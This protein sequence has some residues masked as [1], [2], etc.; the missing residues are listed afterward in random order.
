MWDYHS[1][2]VLASKGS[3]VVAIDIDNDK[4]IKIRNGVS[5]FFEPD[6]EKTLRIG[7]K[8]KLIISND[9]SLIKDCNMIFVAVGTPQKSN[10]AI[11]LSM[12]KKAVDV[13]WKNSCKK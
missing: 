3:N 6:L 4:C 7:L 9:F 10:G 13:Y 5:P 11:E 12:I 2:S 1:A 8:K